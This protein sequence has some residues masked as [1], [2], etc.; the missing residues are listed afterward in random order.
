MAASTLSGAN[1][2]GSTTVAPLSSGASREPFRPKEC[3]SGSTDKTTSSGATAI[4]SA[5]EWF[6]KVRAAWLNTAPL[7]WPVLPEL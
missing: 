2:P 7:G 3:G 1:P 6:A 5:H 4:M